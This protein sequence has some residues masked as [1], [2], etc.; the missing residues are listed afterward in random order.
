MSRPIDLTKPLSQRDLQ[1]LDERPWLWNEIAQ[2][3]GNRET[4]SAGVPIEPDPN[5]PDY[6]EDE[7]EDEVFITYGE[8]KLPMLRAELAERGLDTHGNK[9]ELVA[10]LEE[11]DEANEAAEADEG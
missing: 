7:D 6:V 2:L 4:L 10:R 9:A 1:Y 5:D 3:G 8:L 11:D